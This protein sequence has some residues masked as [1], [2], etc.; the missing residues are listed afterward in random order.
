MLFGTHVSR[1]F[2]K[3]IFFDILIC[4]DM[5]PF[6]SISKENLSNFE[7]CSQVLTYLGMR[8]T[9]LGGVQVPC[10]RA[11]PQTFARARG[12]TTFLELVNLERTPYYSQSASDLHQE[13]SA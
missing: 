11:S 3:E 4:F 7:C 5:R 8:L 10:L 9:S 13:T 2:W 1:T 12:H 6:V